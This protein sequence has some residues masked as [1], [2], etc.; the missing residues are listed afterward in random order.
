M[1]FRKTAPNISKKFDVKIPNLEIYNSKNG[2]RLF[3]LK[4]ESMAILRLDIK[5]FAGMWY[6]K[7]AFQAGMTAKLLTEGT[8]SK[9][10]SE[11]SKLF[12]LKGVYYGATLEADN[13]G[14]SF[15]IQNKFFEEIFPLVKEIIYEASF[16]EK[17]FEIVRK[18]ELT[19]LQLAKQRANIMANMH[20][21][22][23]LFGDDLQYGYFS[24]E[25]DMLALNID[26]LKSFH[27]DYYINGAK[28]IFVAGNLTS[29]QYE[30][31]KNFIDEI[32]PKHFKSEIKI[33]SNINIA[34][35]RKI[36]IENSTQ[37]S[38]VVGKFFPHRFDDDYLD[39]IVFNTL[40]GGYFGSRLNS[41]V[42]EE[43]GLTYGINSSITSLRNASFFT[44]KSNV[45]KNKYQEALDATYLEIEKLR[46]EKITTEELERVKQ[47][48]FGSLLNAM[49]GSMSIIS[50]AL[51]LSDFDL[52]LDYMNRRLESLENINPD[53][54]L[55]LAQKYFAE[56]DF[57]EIITQ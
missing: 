25:A 15:Y 1:T 39:L 3:Y 12:D 41:I 26:D 33:N 56:D 2:N 51:Y 14:L 36:T 22:T 28:D 8:L 24:K 42:R 5:F 57:V 18:N 37:S 52:G 20:F 31:L 17:E 35:K 50:N 9:T 54:I 27:N 29:S 49:D 34:K 23:E 16:P 44:I 46:Q 6:Q 13:S 32:E 21:K 30:I 38:M 19:N 10:S 45:N 43:K 40:L 53:R 48:T 55:D 7:K 47:Y 11:L 4:D